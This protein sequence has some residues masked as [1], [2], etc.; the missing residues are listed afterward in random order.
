MTPQT[1]TDV[2]AD[3]EDQLSLELGKPVPDFRFLRA[4]IS[5]ARAAWL[6]YQAE[7]AAMLDW[8]SFGKHV[9]GCPDC[10]QHFV[11]GDPDWLCETGTSLLHN[12]HVEQL[13]DAHTRRFL[14]E[15]NPREG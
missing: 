3:I 2:L 10:Y 9:F 15:F 14:N 6:N 11:L 1:L 4:R 12:R 7:D 13:A 8:H 5:E